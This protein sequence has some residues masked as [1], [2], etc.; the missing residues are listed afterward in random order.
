M[1]TKDRGN[2]VRNAEPRAKVRGW[3]NQ[4]LLFSMS[5]T[6]CGTD[7]MEASFNGKNYRHIIYNTSF[8]S[9]RKTKPHFKSS[10]RIHKLAIQLFVTIPAPIQNLSLLHIKLPTNID[11]VLWIWTNKRKEWANQDFNPDAMRIDCERLN[12]LLF[13]FK[14]IFP[15]GFNVSIVCFLVVCFQLSRAAATRALMGVDKLTTKLDY[16]SPSPVQNRISCS[17]GSF[18]VKIE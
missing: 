11:W 15:N 17:L 7:L 9:N 5:R 1:Q 2:D 3:S 8:D 16:S 14:L 6:S 13:F 12:A 18:N 4:S 10:V